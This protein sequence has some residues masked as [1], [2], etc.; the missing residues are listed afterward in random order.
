[1]TSPDPIKALDQS[2]SQRVGDRLG[3]VTQVQSAGHVVD[4]VLDRALRIKEAATH[5]RGVQSVC[6]QLENL[7]LP[8]RQHS[9]AQPARVQDLA[10]ESTNLV[11]QAAQQV[12]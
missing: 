5:F 4:D 12:W 7:D 11:E 6:Q 8:V 10:L 1:M 9:K 2:L 3:A